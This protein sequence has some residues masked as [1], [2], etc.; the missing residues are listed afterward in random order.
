MYYAKIAPLL[1]LT[2]FKKQSSKCIKLKLPED[3]EPN[4][5]DPVFP[6]TV[7]V[8]LLTVFRYKKIK[9][10]IKVKA[11][12]S[13]TSGT[14]AM[15]YYLT[16][17]YCL[18]GNFRLNDWFVYRRCK[19]ANFVSFWNDIFGYL[20]LNGTNLVLN[21]NDLFPATIISY[22]QNEIENL[23]ANDVLFEFNET[24]F[25]F[26]SLTYRY[27]NCNECFGDKSCSSESSSCSS[28]S[29]SFCSSSSSSCDSSSSSSSSC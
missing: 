29:S 20:T 1:T 6:G 22:K 17:Y 25:L 14:P 12:Y 27:A 16:K 7:A 19:I 2:P 24:V 26:I 18:Y 15:T 9:C 13:L 23:F 3:Y 8:P 21:P 11:R 4:N 5:A 28:S 10:G